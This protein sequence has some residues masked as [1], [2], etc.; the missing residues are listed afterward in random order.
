MKGDTYIYADDLMVD[1][2][3]YLKESD[4][5]LPATACKLTFK[6][7]IRIDSGQL[8][9]KPILLTDEILKKNGFLID[10]NYGNCF[11]LKE[12]TSLVHSGMYSMHEYEFVGD[13]GF[14]CVSTGIFVDYVHEL[15]HILR[16]C[17]I[18]K[19][20]VI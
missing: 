12:N 20:I 5:D 11:I 10:T 6:N 14:N 3:V 8:E 19:K 15:Q 2:W 4:I 17:E 7:L 18:D 13:Y 1:D 9:A 16:Q